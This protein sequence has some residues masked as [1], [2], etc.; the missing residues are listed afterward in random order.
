M[1]KTIPEA[2]GE[3]EDFEDTEPGGAERGVG[4]LRGPGA[5]GLEAAGNGS[6]AGAPWELTAG[7]QGVTAVNLERQ[8][9]G[10]RSARTEAPS[11]WS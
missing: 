10:V 3:A 11:R 8:P 1:L 5:A 6:V 4:W 9:D 2:E 7:V